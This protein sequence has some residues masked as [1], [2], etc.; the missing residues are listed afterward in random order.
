MLDVSNAFYCIGRIGNG[1]EKWFLSFIR[2]L[3]I[4]SNRQN[5]KLVEVSTQTPKS[6]SIFKG[7]DHV[8]LIY[9]IETLNGS[10]PV[11]GK[12]KAWNTRAETADCCANSLSS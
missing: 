2:K 3:F 10:C 4:N 7:G 8:R 5:T 12:D 1:D 9:L 11:P 6:Y